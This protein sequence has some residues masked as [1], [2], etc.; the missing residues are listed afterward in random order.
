MAYDLTKRLVVGV[1][2]SAIFD[3]AS[4]GAVFDGE[5]EARYRAR[6]REKLDEPFAPGVAYPFVERLLGMNALRPQDDPDG[7]LVEVVLLSRNDP[8]TGRRA[9]R[10]AAHYG[11]AISRAAFLAGG[12]PHRYLGAFDCELFLSANEAD[13]R[14]AIEA[15]APAGLVLTPPVDAEAPEPKAPN[16]N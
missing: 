15:G 5:G 7:P 9:L 11:L 14:A 4:E 10:S 3:T 2:S 12:S 6:Q 1:A 16:P 8:D 13:V